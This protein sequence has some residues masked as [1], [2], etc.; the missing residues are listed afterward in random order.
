MHLRYWFSQRLE[1]VLDKQFSRD[2]AELPSVRTG[3]PHPPSAPPKKPLPDLRS[4]GPLPPKPP[5][6]PLVDLS[7]YHP[8]TVNGMLI[9]FHFCLFWFSISVA[10]LYMTFVSLFCGYRLKN[11]TAKS[12]I[13]LGHQ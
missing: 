7:C 11:I 3:E 9:C 10:V 5:R 1:S 13:L 8:P 4:L 12:C 2:K 6:P